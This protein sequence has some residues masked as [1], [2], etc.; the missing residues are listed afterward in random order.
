[1][2][3]SIDS[4]YLQAA[5]VL[6]EELSF[7][8]AAYVLR[9]SQPALSKQIT[10]LE[11]LYQLRLF[12]RRK[13][14][15]V[16][17]T[18]AGRAFVEEARSALFHTQRA[19]HSARA[20]HKGVDR[21]LI[22]GHAHEA[23]PEWIAAML[24]IRLP[25]FP[26]LKIRLATRFPMQLIR[27]VLD[28]EL[29]LALVAAPPEDA[30]LTAV[31]FAKAPVYVAL[32]EGHPGINNERLVLRDLSQDEWIL[33]ARQVNPFIYDAIVGVTEIDSMAPKDAHETFTAEQA[34][35][36]VSEH[37]G[38]AILAGA[39]SLDLNIKGVTIKPLFDKSLI[40][41]TCLIIRRDE[42]SRAINEFGRAFLKK[43][44]VRVSPAPQMDLPLSA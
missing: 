37:A 38:V 40:F 3:P 19:I 31:H 33:F 7:T 18:D 20:A 42:A 6:A 13:G 15:T 14:R 17:I 10:E 32:P 25:L 44:A 34:I 23:K 30:Q 39:P 27:G 1:M 21:I 16:E 26:Q 9:I 11:D 12:M 29:N 35:Y 5:V 2:F 4:R 22:V 8:R 43:Y 36:L 41:D 28:G 24:A